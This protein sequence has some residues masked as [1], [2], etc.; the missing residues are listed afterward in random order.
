MAFHLD[1]AK[2]VNT[3]S[4]HMLERGFQI[5]KA[6]QEEEKRKGEKKKEMP[7]LTDEK[8]SQYLAYLNPEVL[9]AKRIRFSF[10]M[11]CTNAH[12]RWLFYEHAVGINYHNKEAIRFFPRAWNDFIDELWPGD[13]LSPTKPWSW[14]IEA[15]KESIV[16]ALDAMPS[17]SQLKQRK[18]RI[19]SSRF[20]AAIK[21]KQIRPLKQ[22]YLQLL[23]SQI[24]DG[25]IN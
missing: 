16:Q 8:I 6:W 11:S 9:A 4:L 5:L 25:S 7:W 19:P 18:M 24:E 1:H 12:L 21:K 17:S 22:A 3:T 15:L 23:L 14:E 13:A 10:R 2:L 20:K